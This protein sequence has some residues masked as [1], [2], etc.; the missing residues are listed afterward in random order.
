M[1]SGLHENVDGLLEGAAHEGSAVLP[2]D[3]VPRN[4]HEVALGGH[5]VAEQR[6]VAVVHV[7]AVEVEHHAHLLLHRLPDGLDAEHAEDL[8]DIVRARPHGV[9]VSLGKNPHQGRAVR[10]QEP[11][12]DRLELARLRDHRALLVVRA[13][14]VHVHL[15]DR[16]QTLQRHVGQHVGLDATKEHVVLH[17]V[18]LLLV[19]DV[20]AVVRVHDADAEHELLGVVVIEDAV[21]VVAEAGVDL[22][23][24]LLHGQFLV[25]HPL[26]VQ[27][28]PEQP[29]RDSRLV[30]VRHLVVDVD[31]L[32][33]LSDD[34]VLR[35]RVVVDGGVG[36]D[37][38]ERGVLQSAED[39]LGLLRVP[40]RH[41]GKEHGQGG[42]LRALRDVDDLL[43]PER[44]NK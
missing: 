3:A 1:R 37:P 40:R 25:R 42:G 36:R 22:L 30:K 44:Q 8:A 11:F 33:V 7:D 34:R 4:G 17:L 29:G 27:L 39:V 2:V 5:D 18:R 13:G 32:L 28:D 16:L 9:D 43:Q 35:V 20:L 38:P 6:Q 21:E 14:Q 19:P 24:D 12:C 26:P 10:F 31:E 41:S 23:A 15:G